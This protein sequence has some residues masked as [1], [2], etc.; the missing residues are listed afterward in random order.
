M[1]QSRGCPISPPAVADGGRQC[2]PMLGSGITSER[3][4][5]S[6]TYREIH[7]RER[8]G[9]IKKD[10]TSVKFPMH[11]CVFSQVLLAGEISFILQTKPK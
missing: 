10:V 6:D 9:K 11:S 7:G 5:E 3:M 4:V 8:T 2:G 1:R